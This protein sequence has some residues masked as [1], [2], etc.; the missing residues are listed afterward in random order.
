VNAPLRAETAQRFGV[1]TA[2]S[3]L[4]F[5]ARSTLHTVHGKTTALEG[6]IDVSR[7]AGDTLVL[8]PLPVMRISFA[9]E[10]LR[11][12]NTMMDREMWKLIDSKRFPRITAELRSLQASP[13]PGHYVAGGDVTLAGR[14]KRYE[15]EMTFAWNGDDAVLDGA[16]EVDIRDFGL[17]PPTILIIKVNPV[18][19]VQ[20]HLVAKRVP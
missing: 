10:Q 6:F 18:V 20:L 8:D 1:S 9:V 13:T 7:G 11:S 15:G 16:L 17:I 12:G 3:L 4:T 5:D 14:T 19:K 2:G